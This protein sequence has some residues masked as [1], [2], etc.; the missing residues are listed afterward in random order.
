MFLIDKQRKSNRSQTRLNYADL[1]EGTASGDERIWG[2]L[3]GAKSF[4]PDKFKRYKGSQVNMELLRSTGLREPFVIEE[5]DPELDM[6]M[7]PN[8]ITVYDIAR[9]VGGDDYPVEVI[10]VASQS[11]APGWTMGRWAKYFHSPNRDR[12]RNVI[13]LEISG[14]DL[15]EQVTRPKIVRELDWI[16]LMWPVELHPEEFPRVQLYC[17]MGTKDSYTDL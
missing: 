2:R 11:E 6:K 13:S 5:N 10:D 7:P 4:Q 14:S 1:N 9:L 17:L 3:L 16:D 15:A 12:I 8:D